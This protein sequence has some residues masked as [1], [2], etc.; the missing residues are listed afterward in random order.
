MWAQQIWPERKTWL[1]SMMGAILLPTAIK[2]IPEALDLMW[3]EILLNQ[4]S[5]T[6][7]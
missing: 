2:T 6:T 4:H 7:V 1:Q 5:H 3:E